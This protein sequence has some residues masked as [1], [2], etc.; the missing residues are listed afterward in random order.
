ML[1]LGMVAVGVAKTVMMEHLPR[2]HAAALVATVILPF[3][4]CQIMSPL[5]NSLHR[6]H[7]HAEYKPEVLIMASKSP[8][9][10]L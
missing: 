6:L 9:S 3:K 8:H 2:Q 10:N 5:P 7:S 4:I 1:V